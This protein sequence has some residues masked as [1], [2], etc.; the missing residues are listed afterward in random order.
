MKAAAVLVVCALQGSSATLLRNVSAA[1]GPK[2]AQGSN[3]SVAR[4]HFMEV[5]LGPFDSAEEACDV[6]FSSYTK[7]SVDPACM[8]MAYPDSGGYNMF[9]AT[10]ASATGYV[11]S[12]GGCQ[13]KEKDKLNMGKTS[14]KPL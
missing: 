10:P 12:K 2:L 3:Q 5:T 7:D 9:C 8:C 14:C 4:P 6:C 11:A 1:S 13:C